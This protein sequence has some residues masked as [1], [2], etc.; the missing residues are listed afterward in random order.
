MEVQNH[1]KYLDYLHHIQIH[2]I[3]KHKQISENKFF[4]VKISPSFLLI[5]FD[6]LILIVRLND[7]HNDN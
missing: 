4:K 6:Y 3:K 1:I 2:F 5:L 7:D